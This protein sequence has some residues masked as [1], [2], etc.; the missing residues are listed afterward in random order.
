VIRNLAEKL[1]SADNRGFRVV[2]VYSGTEA[3]KSDRKESIMVY[4]EPIRMLSGC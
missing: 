1:G 3:A 2:R 4:G